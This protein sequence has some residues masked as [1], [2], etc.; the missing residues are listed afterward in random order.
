MHPD[1]ESLIALQAEDDILESI[2]TQL[3]AIAP[4]LAALDG[5]RART[6]KSVQELRGTI[7]ADDRK[8]VD[9]AQRLADHKLKHEKNVAQL[10]VVKRMREATAA[11]SQVEMGRK[12]L[13]ELEGSL[14]DVGNRVNEA[15]RVLGDREVE[16]QLLDEEQTGARQALDA[17]RQV[18]AEQ[19]REARADRDVKA[20]G[21]NAALRTK[22]DRIRQRR[23][24]QS[25]FALAAGACGS[26]DTAIPVHRRQAMTAS[27]SVE[28][29]EACGVL[30]YARE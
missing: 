29:C 6:L 27:G 13:V 20:A 7:E 8:R 2:Q 1:V 14:R 30:I 4:R 22:Y 21:L 5:A 19:L 26:C 25:L 15:R 24:A 10:D 16:L 11:V 9:L 3:D 12:V 28:V 23:R 18:L 17:E